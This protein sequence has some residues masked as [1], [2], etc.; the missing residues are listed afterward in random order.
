[1]RGRNS[2]SHRMRVSKFLLQPARPRLSH[3]QNCIVRKIGCDH[4]ERWSN[5]PLQ[6]SCVEPAALRE[7]WELRPFWGHFLD[8]NTA[9]REPRL[10]RRRGALAGIESQS[11]PEQQDVREL[12]SRSA[13]RPAIASR[14]LR[15]N[16]NCRKVPHSRFCVGRNGRTASIKRNDLPRQFASRCYRFC[17]FQRS[18]FAAKCHLCV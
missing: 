15:K 12:R 14:Q 4:A 11:S 8:L 17:C 16:N 10:V 3:S 5:A 18:N 1:M 7:R 6:G 2:K 9:D 13:L